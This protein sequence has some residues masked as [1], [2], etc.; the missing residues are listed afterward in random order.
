MNSSDRY[1]SLFQYY[2]K[3]HDMDWL[4]MKAQ[5]KI[6]SNFDP[7][8]KSDKGAIGLAQFMYPTFVE[9]SRNLY[10]DNPSPYDPEDSINCQGGYMRWIMDNFH[11]DIDKSLA[12]YNY[13]F[14][15]VMS[16]DAWPMQT[17]AYIADVKTAWTAYQKA[18]E[19][20]A[21]TV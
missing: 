14:G 1:D 15:H 5:V 19:K 12:A 20:D 16:G 2:A 8:V 18:G 6:E 11:N 21:A 3:I 10:I 17:R 7:N 13:G 4:L 9:W